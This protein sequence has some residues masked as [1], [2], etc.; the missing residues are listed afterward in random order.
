MSRLEYPTL[1]RPLISG[2]G[3]NSPL[4]TIDLS[5]KLPLPTLLHGAPTTLSHPTKTIVHA[6][7]QLLSDKH[8]YANGYEL[9]DGTKVGETGH[10]IT[11]GD[12]W[13]NV[14]AKRG[15]YEYIS[16]EG[17]PVKVNWVA[18]ENGFRLE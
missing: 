18:D 1:S 10:L 2:T 15:H 4:S 11:T 12:G 3:W 13:E 16:P 14:I 7:L 17:L 5:K 9:S 6:P 8:E